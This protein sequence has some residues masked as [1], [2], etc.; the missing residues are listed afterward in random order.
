MKRLLIGLAALLPG[1]VPAAALPASLVQEE[2]DL[3]VGWNAI[4]LEVTPTDSACEAVFRDFPDVSRVGC[5]LSDAYSRTVQYDS[6]GKF[7]NQKPVSYLVWCRSGQQDPDVLT[8]KSLQGGTCYLIYADKA[9]AF[10]VTGRPCPPRMAWRDTTGDDSVLNLAG[11]SLDKA[12][13]VTSEAYYSEGPVG[14]GSAI[15]V[16]S[17]TGECPDTDPSTPSATPPYKMTPGQAYL[18]PASSNRIWPGV[19]NVIGADEGLAFGTN[20]TEQLSFRLQNVGTKDH[21]F[22]LTY[23]GTGTGPQLLYQE[24]DTNTMSLVW[25]NLATRGSVKLA[26]EPQE[27]V[28]LTFAIDRRN[29]NEAGEGLLTITDEGP[30]KMRVRLPVTMEAWTAPK[31]TSWPYGIYMGSF[32]LNKVTYSTNSTATPAGGTV[33]GTLLYYAENDRNPCLLQRLC[34]GRVNGNGRT[35]FCQDYDQAKDLS[36]DETKK[37]ATNVRRVSSVVLDPQQPKVAAKAGFTEASDSVT[38]AWTVGKHASTNPMR[39][40]W[41]PDHDGVRYVSDGTTEL[42][43]DGDVLD[44]YKYQVKPEL[45]SISNEVTLTSRPRKGDGR[46]LDAEVSG[47]I[48]WKLYGLKSENNGEIVCTG[49]YVL[50]RVSAAK[51]E[52]VEKQ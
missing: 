25:T 37:K 20:E 2:H 31:G 3:A 32:E 27:E 9:C 51:L 47:Q 39:H 41:H 26:L 7:I 16:V 43:P 30:S 42:A 17:G 29:H 5:Y 28:S 52:T 50:Q 21:T 12:D 13:V 34:F 10:S 36:M 35:F 6:D 45:F 14:S 23:S 38:F 49:K 4:Y 8:L 24:I 33:K 18:V 44:N 1:L 19:I 48:T 15:Y 11:P 22:S 46:S 40:S